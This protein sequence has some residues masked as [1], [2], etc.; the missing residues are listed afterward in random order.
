MMT[1]MCICNRT[2]YSHNQCD[3]DGQ[4]WCRNK[5]KVDNDTVGLSENNPPRQKGAMSKDIESMIKDTVWHTDEQGNIYHI[6][7][8][9]EDN[10][11]GE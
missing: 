6:P 11:T 1:T 9:E 4:G 5:I 8:K 10:G 7:I 2:L 3:N